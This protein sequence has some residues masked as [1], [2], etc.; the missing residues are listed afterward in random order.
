[1]DPNQSV[2][3]EHVFHFRDGKKAHN[4]NDLKEVLQTQSDDEFNHHVDANNNDYANWVEYVYKDKTLADE[5]RKMMTRTQMLEKLGENMAEQLYAKPIKPTTPPQIMEKPDGTLHPT[6]STEHV[7]KFIVK[8]FLWGALL[9][10]VVG[11]ILAW[12]LRM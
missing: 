10:L 2:A 1:M 6:V 7:H 12:I 5:L 11:F 9:G 3:P 4:L 8:E